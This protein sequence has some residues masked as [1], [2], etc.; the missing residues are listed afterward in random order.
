VEIR[1]VNH[2]FFNPAFKLPG[3]LAG[4]EG[5]FRER[6]R[7]DFDRGHIA[8]S[9]RWEDGDRFA[10]E[11]RLNLE[12]AREAVARLREL[13]A[14]VGLTGDI[15]LDLVARQQDVL[16]VAEPAGS[17]ITWGEVEPVVGAAADDCLAMRQREGSV[18]GG[19]LAGRLDA[20]RRLADRV[21]ALAPARLERELGRLRANVA[22]LLDGQAPDEARLAQEIAVL[23]DRLD[24]TEELVRL[25]AHLAA[26]RETV[27]R[28]GP[29]GKSLGFLAQ[30]IGREV[31]TIG[32]KANDAEIA[33]VVISM[34]GELEKFREQVENL[35]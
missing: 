2:R 32:S 25:R 31:N 13:Q 12:R 5:E 8:V 1:T 4:M 17:G 9:A 19:E 20:L 7:R 3:D 28:N 33:H 29:V 30:E 21:E 16:T 22:A 18:L 11:L 10:G 6:L 35:E 24:V 26:G 15:P 27:N 34:K 23:A 14:A